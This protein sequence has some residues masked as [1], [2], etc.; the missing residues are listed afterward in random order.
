MPPTEDTEMPS[1]ADILGRLAAESATDVVVSLGEDGRILFVNDAVEAL[2]GYAK[3]EVLEREFTEL[4][5]EHQRRE[6]RHG[7]DRYVE[8]GE[9]QLSTSRGIELAGRHRDGHD[10]ALEVSFGEFVHRGSRFF[11]A[12]V[13][14][15]GTRI[16]TG[17]GQQRYRELVEESLGLMCCHDLDGVLLA[18]NPPAARALGY[19]PEEMVGRD[20]RDFMPEAV[21][22]NVDEYLAVF[23]DKKTHSGLTRFQHRDG[24]EFVWHFQNALCEEP[25]QPPCVVG[26]AL[27]VSEQLRAQEAVRESEERLRILVEQIPAVLWTT[28]RKLRLTST[29]GTGLEALQLEADELVGVTLWEYFDTEDPEFAPIAAHL[30]ALE[31]RPSNF[32]VELKGHTFLTHVEPLKDRRGETIGVIGVARDITA[33]KRAEDRTREALSLLTATLESTADGLL[34]VDTE[35]KISSFNR[36]FL[37]MWRLD[38]Q[39]I[40]SG[41]DERA[42]AAV[43]DQLKEPDSFLA[44]VQQLY[45]QPETESFDVLEFKDGRVFERYSQPQRIDGTIVGRVW[46][47]RDVTERR[48][49]EERIQRH[50]YHDSLTGLPNRLLVRDRLEMAL[51]AARRRQTEVT[52]LFLDLDNFKL[53]NDT[54]GHSI[55]DELL[56]AVADRLKGLLREG[57]SIG[58]LGGDEFTLVLTDVRRSDDAVALAKRVIDA[59]S[60]PFLLS[61]AEVPM[62]ASV[63]VSVSPTAGEDV[64]FLLQSADAAMYL[65]KSRG[66]NTWQLATPEL[67]LKA[68]R[69]ASLVKSLRSALSNHE[70]EIHYQPI[71]ALPGQEVVGAEALVRWRD[72][73]QGLL[74]PADFIPIAEESHIIVPIGEWVL[75]SACADAAA[76]QQQHPGIRVAVNVSLRQFQQPKLVQTVEQALA[77]AGLG[78]GLL[79]LEIAESVTMENAEHAAEVLRTLRSLGV[80]IS[81]DDFGSGRTSLRSLR[82]LQVDTLKI[83]QSLVRDVIESH[84]AAVIVS[85]I[86][87]MAA[88]LGLDTVAE[89]VESADQLAFLLQKGCSRAQGFL[90]SEALEPSVLVERLACGAA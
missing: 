55:G 80:R 78:P 1:R 77:A 29:L 64:E 89:G 4:I 10:L 36:K 40:E 73:E 57:D 49:A 42:L 38:D 45:D 61:S 35:G 25:G 69:R 74:L 7:F 32:D 82:R 17:S 52:V 65:A 13:R 71:C 16:A 5:A 79:E 39:V 53:V 14:D 44:R 87:D 12:V 37:D 50:A 62:T 30:A 68:W 31:G 90:F 85:A 15:V 41:I 46:S 54:F 59:F 11:T 48:R 81:I 6:Y 8:T 47:F 75:R 9:R 21:H 19:E 24:T 72:P 2:F 18:V 34:V 56:R 88:G 23:A 67:N 20:I 28:D 63:G 58:R 66:G 76:W 26:H 27:D 86:L 22:D 60:K 70:L 84:Q 3:E 51:A 43:L 33:R 83:D